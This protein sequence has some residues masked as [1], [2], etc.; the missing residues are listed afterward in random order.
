MKPLLSVRD[1]SIETIDPAQ[2]GLLVK[3]VS[4]D[5]S[6]GQ[7]FALLGESGS[8]K[9]LTAFAILRL[10][11]SNLRIC[12]G[13]IRMGD[14]DLLRLPNS[15]MQHQRAKQI[16][17]VFQEPM[18]S[19]N[20]VMKIGKQIV[21]PLCLHRH[22]SSRVARDTALGLL[23]DVG[24][25][26]PDRVFQSYPHQ[27]SGGMKQRVM[28]AMA[29]AGDPALLIA[30]EPTTALDVTIQAQVLDLLHSLQ[31]KRGMAMLFISHDLSVVSNVAERIAVMRYGEILEQANATG[32]FKQAQHQY[33]HS[34]YAMLPSVE[35]RGRFLTKPKTS[36]V[37]DPVKQCGSAISVT[38]LAVHFPIRSG[39]FRRVTNTVRAVDGVSFELKQGRT[40]A[41]V[42]ESGS[43]KTTIARALLALNKPTGGQISRI[44]ESSAI[45]PII[46][47][48]QCN[49]QVVFQDPFSSL[50]PKMSIEQIL[51]E[52]LRMARR[53]RDIHEQTLSLLKQVGLADS[54]LRRYP[55][56]LSGGERQRIC[57]ARSLAVEPDF[58]IWDEPTSALDVMVQAQILDLF[59]RLQIELNLGYLFITHDISVVSYLAHEIAV[60]Y[61]G[62]IVEHGDTLEVLSKPAHPYTQTLL[63][64]VPSLR[65][66]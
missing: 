46:N 41:L 43:G 58:I 52:A 3:G 26:D 23:A 10:L 45:E 66:D 40:L 51:N 65:V 36:V 15:Q 47:S 60:I 19:L 50:N 28:I 18:T 11:A 5:I 27:L 33:T 42:G 57:I 13:E 35:K 49:I 29:L 63:S 30:D 59:Q 44:S 56:Q 17:I 61:Q 24:I 4:F 32:F 48:E 64:A 9:S 2:G 16:G 7:S 37:C 1:L 8:G 31:Q 14:V 55:H 20:P 53:H 21:E 22:E 38:D 54:Y 6:E 12:S 62:K 25:P 34:L 39:L